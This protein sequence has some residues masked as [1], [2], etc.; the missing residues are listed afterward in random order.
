MDEDI[1]STYSNV[2]KLYGGLLK[3][4]VVI[5]KKIRRASSTRWRTLSK[6]P[7]N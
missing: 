6:K 3:R 7:K 1:V 5:G 2:K 4:V